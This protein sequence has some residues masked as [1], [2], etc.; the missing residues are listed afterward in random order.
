MVDKVV[1]SGGQM[2]VLEAPQKEESRSH[3]NPT[4]LPGR[5]Y[6][7]GAAVHKN[8]TNFAIFSQ[9][10]TRV[11]LCLFNSD[12]EQTA[13]I[14]LR[15]RTAYVWH[16][17]V[18]D[19]KPGQLYGY[20]IHGPWEPDQGHRFNPNK[21]LV[22]PYAKAISGDVDWKAPIFPYDLASGD[23]GKIDE[24][25]SAAGVPKSVVIDNKFD[26]GDDSLP[27]TPLAD[28]VIYEVHVK[29]FSVRN[30]MVPEKLRGTY[31]GLAHESSINYFKKLGITAVELLP[32]HHFIDEEHLVDKGL[33]DRLFRAD[34]T[35]QFFGRP[36]GTG[37]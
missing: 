26:W 7:L 21:L 18:L 15:E 23:D 22:D 3:L 1:V 37:A 25:D 2:T 24:Q 35:V 28:S 6:P 13:C 27:E 14:A 36:R 10:A 8:G 16:G 4:L 34:V 29:G 33:S 19:I 5:P 20:R 11:E 30:P 17:L 9:D 32:V 12:G 31:A